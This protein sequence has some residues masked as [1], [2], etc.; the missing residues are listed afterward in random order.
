MEQKPKI[1][2]KYQKG[3]IRG[4]EEFEYL[5][6]KIDKEERQENYINKCRAITTM[7]NGVLRNRQITRKNLQIYNSIAKS[8]V[9]RN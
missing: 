5:R 8:T 2:L 4:C 3:C 7:L 6:V 1:I 9:M